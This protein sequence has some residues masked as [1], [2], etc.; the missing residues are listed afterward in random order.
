MLKISSRQ[1]EDAHPLQELCPWIDFI[2]PDIVINKDGS[3]LAAFSFDGVDPEDSFEES[4]DAAT[5]QI[6]SAYAQLDERVMAW[7]IVDK[8]ID[9]SYLDGDFKNETAQYIDSI[10]KQEFVNDRKYKITYNLYLLYTGETGTNKLIDRVARIH[11]EE[12][13]NL[14][15]AVVGAVKESLSGRAAF[16]LQDGMLKENIIAFE[17][18]ISNFASLAPIKLLRIAD[19]DFTSALSILVNRANSPSTV[20]K[21]QSCML[22]SFLPNNYVTSGKDVIRFRGN[23]KTIYAA[24]LGLKWPPKTRPMLFEHVIKMDMEMTICHIVRFL[25]QD[26][27]T[28]E[29]NKAIEYYKLTQY[30]LLSHAMAKMSGV[31]PDPKPGKAL[32]LAEAESA[33][34][35]IGGEGVTYAYQNITIFVYAET[36]QILK[37]NAELVATRL[38]DTK[39][40][41]I[42]E[43]ENTLPSFAAMLPGQWATQTR[44][45]L[46]GIDNVADVTPMFTLDSGSAIHQ[47]FSKEVYHKPVPA[48]T[49]F[50]NSYGGRTYFSP[51]VGQVGHMVIIAPTGTGK[52]T[53]VNFCTSQFQRY[54]D[55]GVYIFDRNRSCE[56]VTALHHGKHINIANE[57]T[58]LN[59]FFAM[60]DG[61][62][63][64]KLW[65]RSFILNRLA[66]GG[67]DA[68][69]DDRNII[70]QQL[71]LLLS[72]GGQLRMSSLAALLPMRLVTELAE[73]L[74]GG[75]FAMFDSEIDDF[76][77]SNWTTIEMREIM[78]NDR[79]SRA[80]MEYA[81]RKI[82]N[83][84][85]GRPTFIYLEEATF[86]LNNPKFAS[87]L[88]DWLKTFR[89]KNAFIW[90]TIQSPSAVTSS[91]ISATL[92][93]NVFTTLLCYNNR[94]EQHRPAYKSFFALQDHQ[95]DLIGKL[96]KNRE[97]LLVQDGK[98]R[99]LD[100]SFSKEVLSFLRSEQGCLNEYDKVRADG[101]ENWESRYLQRINKL[102]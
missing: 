98:A 93:D 7:W 48:L 86:L 54:G 100:T 61:S 39:F 82:Y 66:E 15:T 57:G 27:S 10:Y 12:K 25:G 20:T 78:Q 18:I 36:K 9:N 72:T 3:L 31:E 83:S 64:G 74:E 23:H 63:D 32:L 75:P 55:V 87:T 102:K 67:F 56:I 70:D 22:D 84:L 90:M 13:G 79:L 97:Y 91:D 17:R 29:I 30:G 1:E 71:D 68:T 51:H 40:I 11:T 34:D 52:T 6:Q 5:L 77:L 24:A 42:R 62:A 2:T 8:R 58:R 33:L 43:R 69:A 14:L 35:K 4:I 95:I 47:Y 73:W 46:V 50:G 16:S 101:L 92:L 44:Y 45:E 41:S 28:T 26:A 21:P 99:V 80:F 89:K 85:D 81:F 38:S 96:K 19:D 88:D 94:V 53:F 37:R 59:P 49:T 65:V 76:S 60:Q